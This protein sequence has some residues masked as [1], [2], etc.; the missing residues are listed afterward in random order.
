[1]I[2]M[3]EIPFEGIFRLKV[4][5]EI[6]RIYFYLG[7]ILKMLTV[8]FINSIKR[9]NADKVLFCGLILSFEV[10]VDLFFPLLYDLSVVTRR[11]LIKY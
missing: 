11:V 5:N 7:I 9:N 2:F 3:K 10:S 1:M 4:Q 6:A 8:F